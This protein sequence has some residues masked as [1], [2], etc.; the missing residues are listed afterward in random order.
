MHLLWLFAAIPVVEQC[1]QFA[2]ESSLLIDC[3]V[4]NRQL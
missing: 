1:L 2:P 4:G 3:G